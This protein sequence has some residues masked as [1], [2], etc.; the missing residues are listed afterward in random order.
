LRVVHSLAIRLGGALLTGDSSQPAG[1]GRAYL[2]SRPLFAAV[3]ARLHRGRLHL[4]AGL[5]ALVSIDRGR[6]QTLPEIADGRRAA[7]AAGLLLGGG[8]A[9]APRWRI[10][11]GVEGF[12]A[13]AGAD[14]HVDLGN[15]R[16]AILAPPIWQAVFCARLEFV[17]WP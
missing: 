15:G 17:A 8:L 11:L 13:M 6:T 4:D 10:G 16:Q 3:L 9:L 2:E 14:F 7:L 12:R 1:S 5:V